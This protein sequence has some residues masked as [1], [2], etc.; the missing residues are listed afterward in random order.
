MV[1]EHVW[2]EEHMIMGI[3]L[4]IALCGILGIRAG[5]KA[6][7]KKRITLEPADWYT[8]WFLILLGVIAELV[9][10]IVMLTS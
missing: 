6:V 9:V 8:G 2:M 3:I 1:R 7:Q 10:L 4:G 5:V